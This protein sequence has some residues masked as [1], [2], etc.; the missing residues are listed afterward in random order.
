MALPDRRA[1]TVA[2]GDAMR[3][4][5][6]RKCFIAHFL[7]SELVIIGHGSLRM[8]NDCIYFVSF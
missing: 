8:R 3:F 7:P 5:V 1:R 4:V 6:A 2:T